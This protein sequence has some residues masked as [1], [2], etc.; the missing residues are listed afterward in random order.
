M[1]RVLAQFEEVREVATATPGAQAWQ[2]RDPLSGRTALVKRLPAADPRHKTRATQ[3]LALTHPRIVPTRRWLRDGDG[4][5]VV[6]DF[7]PGRNLRQTLADAR[8]RAFDNL[9]H[10]LTPIL[11]ALD[12]AHRSGLP[13]GGVT[14]ENVL[15]DADGHS[16]LCDFATVENT[17]G[18]HEAYVPRP[19][20]A[21]DGRPT[22]RADFYALCELYKEFLPTRS[23]EDEAGYA[24]RQRLLRNL[25][26]TQQTAADAEELRYKLDAV[27]KMADLLGFSG[28]QSEDSAVL[29]PARLVCAVS[30]ATA[31]LAPGGGTIIALSLANEGDRTL[32]V[33]SVTSDVVWL[34]LPSRLSPFDLPPDGRHELLWTLSGARLLPGSYNA[35]LFVRSNSGLTGERPLDGMPWDEQTVSVPTLVRGTPEA[36]PPDTSAP[37]GP[38]PLAEQLPLYGDDTPAIPSGP[39][40]AFP[41]SEDHPGIAVTQEPDPGL[42]RSGQNGVLHLGVKNIGGQRLRVD[43]VTAFP[44]WLVYPGSFQSVWIEPGATQ[45]LGFSIITTNL[46]GG[47]YKAEVTFVTSVLTET[48]LGLQ[49]T[50]RQMKC[51]VRVRVV[52]GQGAT[53]PDLNKAMGLGC[54]PFALGLLS[55]AGL[56]GVWLTLLR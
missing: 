12:Y 9:Q 17:G 44:S 31:T 52:R 37:P 33:E 8:R 56:F 2:G 53:P 43:T 7:V 10:L 55:L 41:L 54:A 24:A 50:R 21:P 42:A 25:S 4:L 38:P 14:P 6:R 39:P 35:N 47:D 22:P 45:Y 23:P 46:P 51:D 36:S 16:L 3:A 40:P 28:E 30:P 34:N 32:H 1:D 29:R 18:A 26:E 27:A 19:L 5:Y 20:L 48:L 15:V 49:P 13:H 11:D